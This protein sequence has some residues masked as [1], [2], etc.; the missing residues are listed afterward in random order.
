MRKKLHLFI[1]TL[2]VIALSLTQ[3]AH[4]QAPQKMSYQSVLRNS[5]NALI[6]NTAVSTIISILQGSTEGTVVYAETQSAT[7][8]A[9]G[10]LSLQ[11]GA[12]AVITGTFSGIDWANGP[13]FIKTET[14]PAGGS[15]YTITGTQQMMSVPYALYAAKSGDATSIGAISSSSS[16][17]GGTINSGVLSLT[18]ADASNGGIVTNGE[19]TF[20]GN[21]T[22]SGNVTGNTFVKAAGTASQYL[23]ADGSTSTAKASYYPLNFA[24]YFENNA[25]YLIFEGSTGDVTGNLSSFY[26]RGVVPIAGVI[27]SLT[28]KSGGQAPIPISIY[29]DNVLMYTTPA[30]FSSINLGVLYLPTPIQINAGSILEVKLNGTYYG[31]FRVQIPV[32]VP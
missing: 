23:M 28:F 3:K 18:P 16:V 10:L 5:N 2:F 32:K 22:F 14:D 26:S 11:I 6:A 20:A 9:N 31:F 7:T 19:Q 21:K 1:G 30:F 27:N 8:N 15:N 29:K 13:Y 12:G 25:G 17:N 4:G 24:G